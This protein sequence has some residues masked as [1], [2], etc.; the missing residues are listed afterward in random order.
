MFLLELWNSCLAHTMPSLSNGGVVLV[1]VQ[2]LAGAAPPLLT[3]FRSVRR[4]NAGETVLLCMVPGIL[5]VTVAIVEPLF[6][7]S[8]LG[9]GFPWTDYLRRFLDQPAFFREILLLTG[10]FLLLAGLFLMV[11]DRKST[12][13]NSSH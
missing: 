1:Y 3:L 9:N 10:A 13:L 11:R 8:F 5:I 2:M 12:R 7:G 6:F 4:K